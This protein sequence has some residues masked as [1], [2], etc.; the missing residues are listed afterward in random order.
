MKQ[1]GNGRAI[2]AL[3]TSVLV[4]ALVLAFVVAQTRAATL[5][6]PASTE[7]EAYEAGL[8]AVR[9]SDLT[10][11]EPDHFTARLTGPQAARLVITPGVLSVT[12]LPGRTAVAPLPPDC[13]TPTTSAAPA[14]VP[15]PSPLHAPIP[16]ADGFPP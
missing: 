8:Y 14:P 15:S 1:Q 13:H 16:T 7:R 10:E 2:A 3:L 5:Q 11:T 9:L 6:A 4:A 12:R